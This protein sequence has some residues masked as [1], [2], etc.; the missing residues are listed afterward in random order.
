M[1][2]PGSTLDDVLCLPAVDHGNTDSLARQDRVNS[3]PLL[4]TLTP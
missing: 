2:K 1:L 3:A 4:A